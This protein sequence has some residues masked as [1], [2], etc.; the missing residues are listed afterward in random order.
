MTPGWQADEFV[1]LRSLE[2]GARINVILDVGTK[3]SPVADRPASMPICFGSTLPGTMPHRPGMR[4]TRGGPGR[5]PARPS[6]RGR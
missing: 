5:R 4:S 3:M 1:R 6:V 2:S